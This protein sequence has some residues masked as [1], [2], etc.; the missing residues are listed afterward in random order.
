[1]KKPTSKMLRNFTDRDE[2]PASS[3]PPPRPSFGQGRRAAADDGAFDF[4]SLRNSGNEAPEP[5]PRWMLPVGI[6]TL[7]FM[8]L[9]G[10]YFIHT[11]LSFQNT[12]NANY[13]SAEGPYPN[14]AVIFAVFPVLAGLLYFA[15]DYFRIKTNIDP[16]TTPRGL[17]V[18]VAGVC[19]VLLLSHLLAL[20]I[21]HQDN[22]YAAQHGYEWCY[23][24]FDPSH[25]HV[26]ALQ[27]Y[28]TA[29]GCPTVAPVR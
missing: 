22:V 8:A 23:S 19:A 21:R 28:I 27:S 2:E 26:Y 1:M 9:G 24:A 25:K 14:G 29:Y 16:F 12:I 10:F 5:A 4:S 15:L 3:A 17:A 7:I 6:A 13:T 20:L 18:T 11:T